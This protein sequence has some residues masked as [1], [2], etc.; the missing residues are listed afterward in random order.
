MINKVIILLMFMTLLIGCSD[1]EIIEVT[2][3]EKG[4]LGVPYSL[5]VI[6][7][8]SEVSSCMPSEELNGGIYCE[9]ILD[10][11]L[12]DILKDCLNNYDKETSDY[13]FENKHSCKLF[14]E[15]TR[16]QLE[17]IKEPHYQLIVQKIIT[18]N[19][20]EIILNIHDGKD[21][22]ISDKYLSS[23]IFPVNSEDSFL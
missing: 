9:F 11:E 17:R 20:K 15:K 2:F 19:N 22:T 14:I 23:G 4:S 6:I 7:F 3:T 10:L 16:Q 12:N 18:Q 13:N 5:M 1:S 8:N 21:C